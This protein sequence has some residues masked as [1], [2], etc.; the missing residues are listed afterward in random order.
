MEDF[1]VCQSTVTDSDTEGTFP[2]IVMFVGAAGGVWIMIHFPTD[3]KQVDERQGV[4]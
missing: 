3:N 1:C 2:N 4:S